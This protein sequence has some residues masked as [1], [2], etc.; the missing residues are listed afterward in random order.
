VAGHHRSRPESEAA[1]LVRLADMVAH[2]SQGNAVDR[3]AMFR[4]A[5]DWELPVQALRDI[6][7]DQPP[8]IVGQRRRAERSPLSTRETEILTLVAEGR[9][10]AEIASQLTL[11]VSTVRT[12]LH[13][14]HSKLEVASRAQA[15]I[16]ANEMAWI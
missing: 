9:R 14:I 7:F 11:S 5:A 8:S 15:V 4:L 13:N 2:H 1:A 10:D 12:H 16:R 3:E 6:V